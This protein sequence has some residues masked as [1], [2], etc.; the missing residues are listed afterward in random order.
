MSSRAP[1]AVGRLALQR[2]RV[3]M[4][5][6]APDSMEVVELVRG[7]AFVVVRTYPT[8]VVVLDEAGKLVRGRPRLAAIAR[9]LR[10]VR[11]LEAVLAESQLDRRLEHASRS[12]ALLGRIAKAL[13]GKEL[14]RGA[15]SLGQDV[16][17]YRSRLAALSDE[18]RRL[19]PATERTLRRM[20]VCLNDAA[21]ADRGVVRTTRAV[22]ATLACLPD[23]DRAS[24]AAS[25]RRWVVARLSSPDLPFFHEEIDVT[26]QGEFVRGFVEAAR[27]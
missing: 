21:R 12:S 10:A 26:D 13:A 7:R 20:V 19:A 27:S 24:P 17:L 16:E 14:R 25:L 8:G 22:G 3:R 9:H 11:H 2:A 15:A 1:D 18:R 23:D 6:L 5:A 4:P